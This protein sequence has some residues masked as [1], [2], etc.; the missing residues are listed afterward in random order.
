MLLREIIQR[1][2]KTDR[3]GEILA[4]AG[5]LRHLLSHRSQ[6]QLRDIRGCPIAAQKGLNAPRHFLILTV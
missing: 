5:A 3:T 4:I 2:L 1:K 6:R